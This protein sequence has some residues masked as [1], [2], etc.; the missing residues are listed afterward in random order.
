MFVD[1]ASERKI[2]QRSMAVQTEGL[3]P[4]QV[5]TDRDSA[6]PETPTAVVKPAVA[7][8]LLRHQAISPF[9][10]AIVD[11]VTADHRYP[12]NS[13]RVT[14][15]RRRRPRRQE[16]SMTPSDELG[17]FTTVRPMS[18]KMTR[19]LS[20]AWELAGLHTRQRMTILGRHYRRLYGRHRRLT[21]R[22]RLLKRFVRRSLSRCRYLQHQ[23][24]V[25]F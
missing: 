10:P 3:E 6:A 8:R 13:K 19:Y 18:W 7:V 16:P 20:E 2:K 23:H 17:S 21:R 4:P 11:Y 5:L 14:N 24:Q 12:D 9:P 1:I 22:H 25:S 15:G